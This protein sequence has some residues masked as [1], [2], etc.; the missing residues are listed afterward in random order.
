[1]PEQLKLY[2]RLPSNITIVP[3]LF[4]DVYMPAADGEYVKVYLYLLRHAADPSASVSVSAIADCFEHTE[5]DILRILSYW[6]K[7]NLLTL[8]RDHQDQIVGIQL[9]APGELPAAK[10]PSS[11]SQETPAQKQVISA[12]RREA[13]AKDADITQLLYIVEKYLA[14]PLSQTD[15]D[16]ILFFHDSLGFSCE[17]IEFLFEYCVSKN[18]KNMRYIETVALNWAEAGIHSVEEARQ[19]TLG[20]RT[21]GFRILKAFGISGRQPVPEELEYISRWT[22]EYGFSMDIILEACARTM[23]AIH[24]PSFPY[25]EE[26]L[27]TWKEKQVATKGDIDRIDS[28]H[29]QTRKKVQRDKIPPAAGKTSGNTLMERSYSKHDMAQLERRLVKHKSQ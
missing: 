22:T 20:H 16:K 28:L 6:E 3:N 8:V 5:K 19:E 24:T 26:I 9:E 10:R 17:L 21:E 4:L 13:C 11:Q 23:R 29:Q 14:K 15:T 12:D 7:K 27:R 25:T 2:N 1:M 18:I